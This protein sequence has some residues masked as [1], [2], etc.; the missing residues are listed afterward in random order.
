ME[1]P[2]VSEEERARFERDG[3]LRVEGL[4]SA[5]ET[6]LMAQVCEADPSIHAA[7]GSSAASYEAN[8]SLP[9]RTITQGDGQGGNT[10][11]WVDDDLGDVRPP[12]SL[13]A[14][15][16]A[17]LPRPPPARRSSQPPTS[18]P[19]RSSEP[20]LPPAAGL[21]LRGVAVRAGGLSHGLA[22]GR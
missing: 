4:F 19:S 8:G 18:L 22:A 12:P 6:A 7:G 14:P 9:A 16:S 21:L 11:F 13:P 5:E 2:A 15:S 10:A 17:P 3:Y 1:V 20:P